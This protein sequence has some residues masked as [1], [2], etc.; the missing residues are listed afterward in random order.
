MFLQVPSLYYG[1]CSKWSDHFIGQNEKE[2]PEF[3]TAE[4]NHLVPHPI[5]Y[6]YFLPINLASY[7]LTLQCNFLALLTYMKLTIN[8][9]TSHTLLVL[10]HIFPISHCSACLFFNISG[11]FYI[12]PSYILSCVVCFIISVCYELIELDP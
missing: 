7:H 10:S 2:L 4:K 11:R 12:H 3:Q 1:A 6:A 9:R 8:I 5:P